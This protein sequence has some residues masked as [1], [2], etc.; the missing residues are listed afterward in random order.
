MLVLLSVVRLVAQPRNLDEFIARAKNRSPLL[1]DAI[2]QQQSIVL[3]QELLRSQLRSLL[4]TLSA[5]YLLAPFFGSNNHVVSLTTSPSSN[6]YGYEAALTNGG[7]YSAQINVSFPILDGGLLAASEHQNSLL[8]KQ[9]QYASQAIERS[10]E[11]SVA[12]LFLTV[13]QWQQQLAMI[14]SVVRLVRERKDVVAEFVSKGLMQQSDYL[15]LDIEESSRQ[16]D[17][18]QARASLRD[19]WAQLRSAC[20][21]ADTAIVPLQEPHFRLNDEVQDFQLNQRFAL[22]SLAL[23]A[24]AAV[25]RTRYSPQLGA[26]ANAGLN[27]VDPAL[28]PH[29]V[30]ISAGLHFGMVLYDGHQYDQQAQLLHVQELSLQDNRD[31]TVLQIRE[32]LHS[33]RDQIELNQRNAAL[34][35]AQENHQ[36]LL[37]S[38]IRDKVVLGQVSV[39][40]YLIAVQEYALTQQKIIQNQIAIWSLTNQ[41]NYLDW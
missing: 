40:D 16:S 25:M 15:L 21:L 34:L 28:L 6:A 26:F 1:H 19:A 2:R 38:M 22:D 7:L 20:L 35:A 24:Q 31:A 13:Y 3:Q 10:L 32:S 33:L 11:K 41:Y 23:D 12:D 37:L 30:G 5:D 4:V 27:A 39:T 8:T 9:S 18:L 36:E 29:N 17:A 14:D